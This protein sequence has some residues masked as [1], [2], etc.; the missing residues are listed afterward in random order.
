MLAEQAI[1]ILTDTVRKKTRHRDY[2]RTVDL[3]TLYS[4]LITGEDTDSL[5]HQFVQRETPEM[6]EQRQRLTQLITPSLASSIIKPFFKVSRNDKIVKKLEIKEEQRKKVVQDMI[7][8]FYGSKLENNGLD[9]FMQ[10]RFVELSFCDPNS[11]IVVE[12][13]HFDP[14]TQFAQ[15]RPFEITSEQAINFEMRNDELQW[16]ISMIPSTFVVRNATGNEDEKTEE[17]NTFT[18]YTDEN[19]IVFK[20]IDPEYISHG[21]YVPQPDEEIVLVSEKLMFAVSIYEPNIGFVPAQRVGYVRDLYTAGRTC[22][23]PFHAAM[24]YFMK[25]IKTVSEMDLTMTLHVFPQKIQYVSKCAGEYNTNGQVIKTCNRG[26]SPDGQQCNVCHGTGFKIHTSA[27]DA[28]MLPMPDDKMEMFDLHNIV[29][30]VNL[31][32]D[33][34]KFL[35]EYI[36][37]LEEKTHKAVFNSNV[38]IKPTFQTTATAAEQDMDSVYDTLLP[39]AKKFS[40]FWKGV[41]RVCVALADVPIDTTEI[42]Y[43]FPTDFKLKTVTLLVA[44]L[45][46][47]NDSGAPSFAKDSINNDLAGMLYAEDKLN[48]LKYQTKQ[49][50]FP[51]NGKTT[52]EVA[53]L[54]GS[55][56]VEKFNKVLYANFESIFADIEKDTPQYWFFEFNKQWD[57]LQAKVNEIIAALPTPIAPPAG[58]TLPALP[59]GQLQADTSVST[60]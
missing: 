28:I 27:Q 18:I 21:T 49:R 19:A 41:A 36:N 3:A 51:F 56:F 52:D 34:V 38:F 16:I 14:N 20:Q 24:P 54:M 26:V 5:L 13:D 29:S 4:Q 31:P 30:Y 42:V 7:D 45:K 48:L 6:F 8:G 23:N 43:T 10:T 46:N 11:F 15:P 57:M 2:D 44:E 35:D 59:A 9:Y 60:V 33:I 39:F 58:G 12:F 22:V 25:S 53:L 55:E 47:L 37:A 50:F 17:G 1:E 40:A 32:I